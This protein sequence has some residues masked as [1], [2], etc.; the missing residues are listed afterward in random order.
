MLQI[1]P[2]A[3]VAV[4]SINLAANGRRETF[5]GVCVASMAASTFNAQLESWEPLIEPFEG[6]FK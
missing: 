5:S 6:I 4:T 1:T 3:N 2:L